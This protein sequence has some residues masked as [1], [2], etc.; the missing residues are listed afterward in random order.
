MVTFRHYGIHL[1]V[2]YADFLTRLSTSWECFPYRDG[3]ITC[4]T[5][6]ICMLVGYAANQVYRE[7]SI[8]EKRCYP[9]S[10]GH[11]LRS[12][13]VVDKGN[14]LPIPEHNSL[15]IWRTNFEGPRYFIGCPC[16]RVMLLFKI[17]SLKPLY[18]S[19]R[20]RVS[21]KLRHLQGFSSASLRLQS[22]FIDSV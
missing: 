8:V 2:V 12:F 11:P 1:L 9:C 16:G 5:N 17:P 7:I 20:A 3:I 13:S 15:T 10:A 22:F 6:Y 14:V 4:L 19:L 21:P 18:E